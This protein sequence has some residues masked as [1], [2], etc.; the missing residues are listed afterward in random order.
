MIIDNT[1]PWVDTTHCLQFFHGDIF[2]DEELVIDV[3]GR[4]LIIVGSVYAK[5]GIRVINGGLNAKDLNTNGDIEAN[6]N[7][8]A[9]HSI[10][11]GKS[12]KVKDHLEAGHVISIYGDVSCGAIRARR[13]ITDVLRCPGSIEIERKNCKTI[14]Q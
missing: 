7:L 12:I 11:A 10:I 3:P 14:I 13:L 8:T 2:T 9:F 5:E 1:T 4:E 6:E